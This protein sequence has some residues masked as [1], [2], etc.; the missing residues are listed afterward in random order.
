M[1]ELKRCPF[2]GNSDPT[3]YRRQH[4]T[5]LEVLH[6]SG[7]GCYQYFVKCDICGCR[8]RKIKA[9]REGKDDCNFDSD[10]AE[11]AVKLWNLRAE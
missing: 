7:G 11:L 6:A 2:C 4:L 1:D 8:S 5:A 10:E 3:L 9:P